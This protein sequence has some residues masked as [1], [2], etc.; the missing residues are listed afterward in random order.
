MRN[1]GNGETDA[2]AHRS[3]SES[4]IFDGYDEMPSPANQDIAWL[5]DRSTRPLK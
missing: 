2:P 4:L 1:S 5:Q 3:S